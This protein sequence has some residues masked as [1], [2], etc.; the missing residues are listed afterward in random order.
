M[1][2]FLKV[3]AIVIVSILIILII[4]P[5]AFKGKI[6]DAIQN[7]ANKNLNAQ[8]TFADVNLSFIRSFPNVSV[9]IDSLTI[10]GTEQ[11]EG[12]TLASIPDFYASVNF[13]SIVRGSNFEVRKV[14]IDSPRIFLKVLSDGTA[15]WNIMKEDTTAVTDTVTEPSE[16]KV[17]LK[18]LTISDAFVVYDDKSLDFYFSA[19]DLDHTLSGDLTATITDLDTKTQ[20]ENLLVSYGGIRYLNKAKATLNSRITADLDKFSFSFPDAQL[21]LNDLELL[22]NGVFE[23]PDNGY[24]MDIKF[25]AVRNDFK[26][27]LSL[28]PAVYAKDFEQVTASGKMGF[29]GYVKGHYDDNTLPAFGLNLNIDN[30]MFK[31]PDLPGS[32]DKIFVNANIDNQTGDPDN[33]KITVDKLSLEM[34]GNPV[35]GHLFATTPVSDPYLDASFKGRVDLADVSKVYPLEEG[36]QLSGIVDADFEIKGRQ[37]QVEKQQFDDFKANGLVVIS[38]LKYKTE[39]FDQPIDIREAQFRLSPKT[40]DMPSM[41]V[42]LGNNDLSLQGAISNY[43]AYAFDKGS[44]NGTMNVQSE[45]FNLNDLMSDDNE[46]QSNTATTELSVIEVPENIDFTLRSSFK[47]VIYDK[48]ELNNLS[49]N[50]ILRDQAVVLNDVKFNTL[51]GL[52]T[53]NGSYSTKNPEVPVVDFAMNINEVDIKKAFESF[54]TVEKLVPIARQTSGKV[55]TSLQITSQLGKDMMP[56]PATLNGSGNLTSPKLSVNNLNTF[57]KIADALKME[58]FKSFS[59]DKINLSFAIEAGKLFVKPFN[60]TLAKIPTEISG[61]NSMDQTMEYTMKMA[62]PTSTLGGAANQVLNNLVTQ[63]NAKGANFSV[64]QTVPVAV[65]VSG[66]VSDPKVQVSLSDAKGGIRESIKETIQQKKEEVVTKVKEE[67]GKYLDEANKQAKKIIDEAQKRADQVIAAGNASA[68]K[69]RD[70]ANARADQL[71][72]EG[73]AKGMIA[74]IAAKKAAEKVRDE[75]DKK[76]DA[77][78]A[79]AKKQADSIM[80]AARTQAD[81]IVADAKAKVNSGGK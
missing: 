50:V 9:N 81:K 51:D 41:F 12:D 61:W 35:N 29:S 66:M 31:Y 28:V 19:G 18:R 77:L 74:E 27:F 37:S 24:D 68:K 63:A 62:V 21:L 73:K 33:T 43:L 1:K 26:S 71:V 15:N 60:T 69:V 72:K 79:E 38:N 76:A 75:G 56:V 2:K 14:N 17:S 11:F 23:M 44:L 78:S 25:Q 49:G 54:V 42:K 8:V 57:N 32:V 67:T 48:I 58:Q 30:G 52:M 34:L 6:K 45:Y 70:E 13:M 40:V 65:I 5:F 22:A 80:S 53:M 47:K 55:S 3:S 46:S 39:S 59:L 64:G 4:L 10:K 16:F 20:I 7:A 36:D